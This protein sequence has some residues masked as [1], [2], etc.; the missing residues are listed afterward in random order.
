M[1]RRLLIWLTDY[2]PCREIKGDQGEPY[3]ER[4]YLGSL[5]GWRAY[6]HRFV[7]SDPDRGLHDHPWRL[8]VSL[9][10]VGWYAELRSNVLRKRRAGQINIIRGTDFHRVILP[11]GQDAWTLFVHGKRTK[12]W[13]FSRAGVYTPFARSADDYPFEEW[14]R[15]V[16]RGRAV[17]SRKGVAT[18]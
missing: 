1:I 18:S 10:L 9:I 8:S 11:E 15:H 14:W 3:L 16:P 6:I 7:D 5:F 12:G 2:L 4:Y 13:G 17:R